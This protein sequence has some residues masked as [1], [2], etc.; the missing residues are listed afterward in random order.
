MDLIKT[1]NPAF[2]KTLFLQSLAKYNKPVNFKITEVRNILKSKMNGNP[3]FFVE[4]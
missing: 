1:P 4:M 3:N 2:D